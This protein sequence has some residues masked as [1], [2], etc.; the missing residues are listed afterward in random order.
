MQRYIKHCK[1]ISP[2]VEFYKKQIGHYNY[3]AYEILQNEI[4][5]ILSIFTI[6]NRQKRGIIVTVLGSI[7]S[8]I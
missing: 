8:G 4:G 1:N 7:A 6:D 5:L 2:Y 3:T